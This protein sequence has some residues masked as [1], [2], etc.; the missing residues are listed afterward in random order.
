[1][2]CKM[3]SSPGMYSKEDDLETQINTFLDEHPNISIETA[4]FIPMQ[5]NGSTQCVICVIFYKENSQ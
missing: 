5:F 4:Y 3:F 2:K 1:M